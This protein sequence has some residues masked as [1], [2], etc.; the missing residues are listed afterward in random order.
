MLVCL[1]AALDIGVRAQTIVGRRPSL[2]SVHRRLENNARRVE[3]PGVHIEGRSGQIKS[4]ISRHMQLARRR[5]ARTICE[6]GFNAGH[7]AATW[8]Y[9]SALDRRGN[10]LARYY[11]FDA[12]RM[13]HNYPE[14]NAALL[15]E[16]LG[17]NKRINVRFGNS[18]ETLPRFV[19]SREGT[20]FVCDL[21]HVDGG[22]FGKVPISDLAWMYLISDNNTRLVMDDLDCTATWC[23]EVDVAWDL[24]KKQGWVQEE[25]C[26]HYAI[27]PSPK[28]GPFP[29]GFCWGRFVYKSSGQPLRVP[30]LEEYYRNTS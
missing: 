22:H 16:M 5:R 30:F 11:G 14:A 21:V 28:K 17:G 1:S 7:S 27:D 15:D 13:F 9:N 23:R 19:K 29:R 26:R 24:A 2:V 3:G 6:T 20:K 8:L 18:L 4:Q 25:A 12:G 10:L